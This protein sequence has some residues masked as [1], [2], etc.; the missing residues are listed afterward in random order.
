MQSGYLLHYA[1]TSQK[2]TSVF[3]SN[4][5]LNYIAALLHYVEPCNS[6]YPEKKSDNY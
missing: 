1:S 4:Y 5:Q 2:D 6:L 3:V